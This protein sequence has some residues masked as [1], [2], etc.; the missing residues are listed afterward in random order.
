MAL[1]DQILA[2]KRKAL[3]ISLL[4]VPLTFLILLALGLFALPWA[5]IVGFIIY[6]RMIRAHRYAIWLRRFHRD[7]PNRLRF[8]WLL[9]RACPGLCVPITIQDSV[10]KTS[11]YSSGS[12]MLVVLPIVLSLG[13]LLYLLCALTIAFVIH[14]LVGGNQLPIVI[15][16]ILALVPLGLYGSG[17]KN[18]M[19]KRGHVT[20]SATKAVREVD[21][22]LRKIIQRKLGFQGVMIFKCA[23][24]VWQKVVA[25]GISSADAVIIDVSDLTENVLWEIET[26]LEKHD[27]DSIL[28]TYGVP[29]DAR[30]EL[31]SEARLALEKVISPE[32]LKRIRIFYY[33]AEQPHPGPNRGRLYTKLSKGLFME[34]AKC[35]EN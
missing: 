32:C 18:Q 6:M 17:I 15:G 22:T 20:L 25:L 35:I 16:M 24:E 28:L 30:E 2:K 5:I 34:L 23:D 13:I 31:P 27:P 21:S 14:F 26:A 4:A 9:H 10:F 8:N 7:E 1:S 19:A 3:M 29:K 12:R 33:P 11:Y